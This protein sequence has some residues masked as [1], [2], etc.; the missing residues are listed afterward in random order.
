[1]GVNRYSAVNSYESCLKILKN[2]E[3]VK[4][5]FEHKQKIISDIKVIDEK[6]MVVELF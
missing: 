1:M 5:P 6:L 2:S 3:D 4:L